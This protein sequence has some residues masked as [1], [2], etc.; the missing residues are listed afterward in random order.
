MTCQTWV[1][2]VPFVAL[3]SVP[4]KWYLSFFGAFCHVISSPFKSTGCRDTNAPKMLD[5]LYCSGVNAAIR[6]HGASLK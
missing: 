1:A 4:K 6:F 5:A 2:V 3:V